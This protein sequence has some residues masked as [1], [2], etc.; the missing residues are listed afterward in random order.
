MN[1]RDIELMRE[2]QRK[3]REELRINK[4]YRKSKY[5]MVNPHVLLVYRLLSLLALTILLLM[6]FFPHR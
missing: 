2:L 5:V 1:I 6:F 3:Y 4:Y